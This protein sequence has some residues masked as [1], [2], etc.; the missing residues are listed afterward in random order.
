MRSG[1]AAAHG[2]ATA[3]H[4]LSE[5]D[6][7]IVPGI[8]HC[9]FLSAI[10]LDYGWR[11]S[12]EQKKQRQIDHH[13]ALEEEVDKIAGW[14]E[15]S[16]PEPG[17]PVFPLRGGTDPASEDGP[18]PSIQVNYQA[19]AIWLKQ[20]KPHFDPSLHAWPAE[21]V[22]NYRDWTRDANGAGSKDDKR[23]DGAPREWNEMYFELEARCLAGQSA[24]Q[25]QRTL[26]SLFSGL[27]DKTFCA[28]LSEFLLNVDRSYFER[29]ALAAVQAVQ[30]RGDV[31]KRLQETNLFARNRDREE[32][33][34]ETHLAPALATICFNDHGFR[35]T[36]CYLPSSFIERADVF[37]P[38]LESFLRDCTTPYVALMY[39]NFMEVAPRPE[40]ASFV[41]SC[42]GIWLGRFPESDR[43]WI[44]W[45]FGRRIC[46]VLSAIFQQ[47][48]EA[49][50]D[51]VMPEVE[52]VLSK[53]VSL[54]APQ[55]YELEQMI[56]HAQL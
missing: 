47:A 43:F 7:R 52:P 48:P 12:D 19:A 24:E 5:I 13:S 39:L 26:E 6:P 28:C 20:A 46:S 2:F 38:L 23:S 44:E 45:E 54:G 51:A 25:L 35:Q 36:K 31:I 29:G 9:A 4:V 30:I 8:L 11:L 18:K 22:A 3:L 14:L 41:A 42:A 40:H 17:W 32:L 37:L 21:I 33:S 15:G 53:L 55:A 16:S 50:C 34:V 27:P 56:Y 10:K 1:Y 49:F